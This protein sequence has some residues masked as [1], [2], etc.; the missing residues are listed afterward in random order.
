MVVQ[1][2]EEARRLAYN[3]R[4]NGFRVL[5]ALDDCESLG[6]VCASHKSSLPPPP[7]AVAASMGALVAPKI[8]AGDLLL[9][10]GTTLF[11]WDGAAGGSP[12][13]R[14]VELVMVLDAKRKNTG[15]RQKRE[16][17]PEYVSAT[18]NAL[19]SLP[20]SHIHAIRGVLAGT[21]T[22]CSRWVTAAI[23]PS[24][25]RCPIGLPVCRP[26]SRPSVGGTTPWRP[27]RLMV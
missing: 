22:T 15:P 27:W 20:S 9:L 7:P 1:G 25:Q 4:P 21:G 23:T 12:L 8:R 2:L 17:S 13:P 19:F 3:N 18:P 16:L 10:S 5:F 14:F 11:A 24:R 26:S 6:V